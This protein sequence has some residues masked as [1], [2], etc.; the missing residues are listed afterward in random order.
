MLFRI[1]SEADLISSF[2]R[3]DQKHVELPRKASFPM[4]FRHYVAWSEPS[5]VRVFI[6]FSRPQWAA[7]LGIVFKRYQSTVVGATAG[8]GMCEWC[9]AHGMSDQIGLLSADVDS[10][11]RV[12]VNLCLDLGCQD[13]IA[14]TPGLP[15]QRAKDLTEQMMRRLARFSKDAL[16]IP[17]QL[18]SAPPGSSRHP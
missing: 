12:G 5:G 16:E 1:D 10:K 4:T 13:R 18:A 6:V 7:P 17:V 2:R 3:R 11:R 15:P 9:H 8:S 14:N